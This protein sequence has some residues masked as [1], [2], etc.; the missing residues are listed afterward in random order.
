MSTP[1]KTSHTILLSLTKFQATTDV[2]AEDLRQPAKVV[3]AFCQDLELDG[4]IE[5]AKINGTIT[6]WRI[7]ENGQILAGELQEPASV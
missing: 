1:M 7:T 6:V 2:I 3:E 5:R 4:L